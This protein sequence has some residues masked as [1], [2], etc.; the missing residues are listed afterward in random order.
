MLA[1]AAL[2]PVAASSS[3]AP[4]SL[5]DL[6]LVIG[7]SSA[8]PCPS[9]FTRIAALP[10]WDGDLNSGAHQ[11]AAWT[12]SCG[13][14]LQAACG[15]TKAP[16]AAQSCVDCLQ[17]NAQR[18]LAANCTQDS[19]VA[20]CSATGAGSFAFLCGRSQAAG[21]RQLPITGLLAFSTPSDADPDGA[22]PQPRTADG[23]RWEKV[24]GTTDTHNLNTG[25]TNIGAMYLCVAR[26]ETP[27]HP[28]T[29]YTRV[30]EYYR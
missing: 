25:S 14:A 29:P 23:S 4:A 19:A 8:A 16:G 27:P 28:R 30:V 21:G 11:P 5:T 2:L 7:A 3:P 10:G 22:C 13:A 18:L 1:A 9:S 6:R 12:P 20:W 15:A 24:V 17:A 26:G